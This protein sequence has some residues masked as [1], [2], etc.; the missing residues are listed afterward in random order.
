MK[1]LLEG[2]LRELY[3]GMRDR[4]PQYCSCERCQADVLAMALNQAKPR[5]TGGT[6][7]GIA[8]TM[9]DLQAASTRASLSVVLL[10]AMRRVGANPN[11]DAGRVL[12]H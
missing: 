8:I 5:Y 11:H 3:D 2:T 1:N 4:Y 9:L 7:Q 12:D 10:D 6:V